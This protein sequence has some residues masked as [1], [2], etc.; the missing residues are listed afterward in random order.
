MYFADRD[1]EQTLTKKLDK[2]AFLIPVRDA[3]GAPYVV[4]KPSALSRL[5]RS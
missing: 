1:G 3:H 4:L 5:F 2:G